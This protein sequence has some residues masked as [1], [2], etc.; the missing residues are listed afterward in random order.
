MKLPEGIFLCVK[1]NEGYNF[2][3]PDYPLNIIAKP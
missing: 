3:G 2:E 1:F